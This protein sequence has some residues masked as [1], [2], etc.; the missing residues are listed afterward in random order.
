MFCLFIDSPLA[1]ALQVANALLL[2]RRG[3]QPKQSLFPL[4]TAEQWSGG[5]TQLWWSPFCLLSLLQTIRR[6]RKPFLRF[7]L[8]RNAS[9]EIPSYQNR[10]KRDQTSLG[11]S[12]LSAPAPGE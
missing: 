12:F 3:P 10:C 6:A 7:N 5:I 2:F 8:R 11:D 4:S 1:V 9:S